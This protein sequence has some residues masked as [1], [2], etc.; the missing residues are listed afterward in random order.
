MDVFWVGN[1]EK[2]QKKNPKAD[3]CV[4]VCFGRSFVVF[5]FGFIWAR[6]SSGLSK[7]FVNNENHQNSHVFV[8]KSQDY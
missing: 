8:G 4:C 2:S 5:F 6:S 1:I 3:T 7:K